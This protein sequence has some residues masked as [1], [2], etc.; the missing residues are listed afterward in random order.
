MTGSVGMSRRPP[1]REELAARDGGVVQDVD[2]HA[3]RSRLSA[4]GQVLG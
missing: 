1:S 4:R 2:V 3:L